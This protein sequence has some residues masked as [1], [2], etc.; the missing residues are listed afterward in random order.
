MLIVALGFSSCLYDDT[1][2]WEKVNNHEERLST[3]EELCG[4]IN[5]NIEALQTIVEAM[6]DGDYIT[7]VEPIE[8][9]GEVVG[10]TIT[11]AKSEAITIY[12][13]K[14]GADSGSVPQIGVKKDADGVYYWTVNGDWLLDDAGNK[15][16]AVGV[17]GKDGAD[18]EDGKDGANGKDGADGED[19]KDGA[20]GK[21]GA[22]GEDGKNGTN[23]TNGKDGK[24]GVTPQLKIENNYWYVSYDNGATWTQLG[25]STADSGD[26]AGS[27]FTDVTID[28]QYVRFT[29]ADGTSIVIPF[30]VDSLLSSL[31]D[32][33]FIPKYNGGKATV[34]RYA[35]GVI[36]AE[37]DFAVA[38]KAA[39]EVIANNFEELLTVNAVQTLTR[40]VTLIN[41]PVVECEAD[42][43][44]GI[45][46]LKASGQY[47]NPAAFTGEVTYSAALT[48]SDGA[49]SLISDYI[50]LCTY[51]S[52]EN[53][54]E[55]E[56]ETPVD[57][58]DPETP[59][60]PEEPVLPAD[61]KVIYYTTTDKAPV[62]LGATTGFGGILLSNEYDVEADLGKLTFS[63]K[64]TCIPANAFKSSTIST[65]N[66]PATVT[67]IGNDAF[68]ESKISEITIP[69]TVTS[70]GTQVF[71]NC[72]NLVTANI[73]CA[74]GIPNS[75][76][77]SCF[78]DCEYLT[79]VTIGDSV[80][81][82]GSSAFYYCERLETVSIGSS[83]A[84][85]GDN[86]F[87]Q[88]HK[89]STVN[90]P[91][92]VKSIGYH[93][94][95]DC[96]ALETIVIGNGVETIGSQAFHYCGNLTSVTFG[97]AI[98]SVGSDAFENCNKL[99]YFYINDLTSYCGIDY[100]DAY[101]T[102]KHQTKCNLYLNGNLVE[103]LVVPEG[104]T[105]IGA[106]AFY[107]CD[108]FKSVTIP[109]SV[110]TI[111]TAAFY[112]CDNI[113]SIDIP[114]VNN[115]DYTTTV[116]NYAFAY[117]SKLA[118][119]TIGE[120]ISSIGEKAFYCCN[121][122]QKFYCKATN[123]PSLGTNAFYGE[124]GYT[125]GTEI[126]VPTALVET[127]KG[128]TNWRDYAAYIYGYEF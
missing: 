46:S 120:R 60:D 23:G 43:T 92:S 68:Y 70:L 100:S 56:P 124:N 108:S 53:S 106:Y 83:V 112:G 47:L 27:L 44:K 22:D 64:V 5:S 95:Y 63:A 25:R 17:D 93:A 28:E 37:F 54:P 45:I 127:Y 91:D 67:S 85:I 29:L 72:D 24:D 41:M 26:V 73:N 16:K 38:P 115:P 74:C 88:C 79:S 48:I 35:D 31:D 84:S 101:A 125:I 65:I 20:N 114:T 12:N 62:K 107:N 51:V 1:P 61:E 82:I 13:G 9:N 3:L 76:F 69:N 11:F 39:A 86:V 49:N 122:L 128:A 30:L 80:T 118:K 57:P 6:E 52:S 55:D 59:V 98:K 50:E 103:E 10:Y 36:L 116:G 19:G 21:D 119:V 8:E 66:F 78:Y 109:D 94:F 71:S 32:M 102:P 89:L 15:V 58:E 123:V 4:E 40:S 81:S 111:S 87:S 113:T 18:G 33:S 104:I 42:A 121:I 96:D 99:E 126:Y 105:K 110:K 77:H 7:K 117:C 34:T 2:L 90:I 14:D 97:T 75:S